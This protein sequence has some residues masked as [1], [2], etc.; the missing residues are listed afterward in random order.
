MPLLTQHFILSF[1]MYL[2]L[3]NTVHY[4]LYTCTIQWGYTVGYYTH[5]VL[6]TLQTHNKGVLPVI[7]QAENCVFV[8]YSYTFHILTPFHNKGT[9]T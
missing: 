4:T 1:P 3:H 7:S 5:Y 6:N 8:T 2:N 9:H